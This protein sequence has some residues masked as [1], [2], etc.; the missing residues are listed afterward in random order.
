MSSNMKSTDGSA[1]PGDVDSIDNFDVGGHS[2]V[3]HTIVNIVCTT[4]GVGMVGL[5]IAFA[6]AGWLVSICGM[7][8]GY[9]V[10]LYC[11]VILWRALNVYDRP[12]PTF[13]DL[14]HEVAGLPG[15][16]VTAF[17]VYG[18]CI[19][20][21]IL[22]IILAADQFV[23]IFG[24]NVMDSKLWALIFVCITIPFAAFKTLGHVA[25]VAVFG[26]LASAVVY[27]VVVV[28]TIMEAK[29]GTGLAGLE[30]TTEIINTD[31]PMN[32]ITAINTF[33]FSFGASVI[34]AESNIEMKNRNKFPLA[35]GLAYGVALSLYMSLSA[36]CYA[37]YGRS[38]LT[39]PGGSIIGA[40]PN[41]W[42]TKMMAAMFLVHLLSAFLVLLNPVF[43]A[44]ENATG[45]DNRK[46]MMV[47]RM[48]QRCLM[49]GICY[50]VAIAIPFFGQIM[51]LMGATTITLSSFVCPCWF[52][53][54]VYWKRGSTPHD[55]SAVDVNA[56]HVTSSINMSTLNATAD[57][58]GDFS[59]DESQYGGVRKTRHVPKWEVILCFIIV[60]VTLALGAV[61][62]YQSIN[63]IVQ[64]A[65]TLSFF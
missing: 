14:G 7:I 42:A 22:F 53:L 60:I 24:D 18:T 8:G 56:S 58:K 41:N 54:A 2:S 5:P 4:V 44:I 55:D 19:G 45:S 9:I 1:I 47:W 50:F 39:A 28:Q 32:I 12:I 11:G 27:V 49:I 36:I 33:I 3:W 20:A 46:P 31:N 37:V 35:V 52:Y 29:D 21:S 61:G 25:F 48:V 23:V 51:S 65:S 13:M 38:L 62:T 16:I 59:A 34:F 10:S 26:A 6:Q 63:S 43:R 17:S 57:G 40:L 15:K 64:S 30:T